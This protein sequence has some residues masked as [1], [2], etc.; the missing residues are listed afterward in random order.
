MDYAEAMSFMFRDKD[1]VKKVLIGGGIGF[2]CIYSG[3]LF[4]LIFILVGY[5]VGV[6]RNASGAKE[7][8]L[9]DW[10][11]WNQI[12][13][14]GILGSIIVL[15]HLIVIGGILAILIVLIANDILLPDYQKGILI[16]LIVCSAI[17]ALTIFSNLGIIQFSRSGNFAE[18]LSLRKVFRFLK[19][20]FGNFI[21]ITIFSLILNLVLFLVGL[22]IFSPLTNFW[23]LIVQAHLFGQCVSL[24]Q[25]A[26][27]A[28]QTTDTEV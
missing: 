23:G 2:V 28:L 1:W 17:F 20:N 3:I 10:K 25:N 6:I 21:A 5:Y 24:K 22:G 27:T 9:P 26:A 14:D 12:I 7:V 11:E 13:V 15:I 8:A 4:F 16:T 19:D 18:A